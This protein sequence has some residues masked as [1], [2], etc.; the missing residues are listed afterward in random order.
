MSL[1]IA[2]AQIEVLTQDLDYMKIEYDRLKNEMEETKKQFWYAMGLSIGGCLI[3]IA[4]LLYTYSVS[5]S[6]QQ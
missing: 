5:G 2:N 4:G 6:M 3:G 1:E